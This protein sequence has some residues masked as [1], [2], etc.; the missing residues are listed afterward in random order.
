MAK[1]R[2]TSLLQ[3]TQEKRALQSYVRAVHNYLPLQFLSVLCQNL[4]FHEHQLKHPETTHK[5]RDR[6]T[7]MEVREKNDVKQMYTKH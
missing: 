5:R 2:C 4:S 3:L 7:E 1:V 6:Y